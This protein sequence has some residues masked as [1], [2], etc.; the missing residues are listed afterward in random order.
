MGLLFLR[1]RK[2]PYV[3]NPYGLNWFLKKPVQMHSVKPRTH[4]YKRP[5]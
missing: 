2:S 1:E 4:P 3:E 5:S